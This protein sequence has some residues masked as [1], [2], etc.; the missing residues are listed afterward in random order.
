MDGIKCYKIASEF[1]GGTEL[2]YLLLD[3]WYAWESQEV[4]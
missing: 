3:W 1:I 2:K 4:T